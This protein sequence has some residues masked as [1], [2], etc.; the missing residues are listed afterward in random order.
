MASVVD[1]IQP[2]RGD[3]ELF[4]DPENWQPLCA[5]H[6]NSTKRTAEKSGKMRPIIGRDGWPVRATEKPQERPQERP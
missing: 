5:L 2:H 4:W 1:H 6:H 3:L